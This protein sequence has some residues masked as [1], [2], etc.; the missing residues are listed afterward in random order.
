MTGNSVVGNNQ[1]YLDPESEMHQVDPNCDRQR[2]I[3]SKVDGAQNKIH[4]DDQADMH[5]FNQLNEGQ[6][7][8]VDDQN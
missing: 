3:Q 6:G 2:R 4:A 5:M 1:N 7:V 8:E